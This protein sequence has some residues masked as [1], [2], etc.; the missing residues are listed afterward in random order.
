MQRV[1]E[2]QSNWDEREKLRQFA[3]SR[4]PVIPPWPIVAPAY[5]PDS[6]PRYPEPSKDNLRVVKNPANNS[7]PNGFSSF[8]QNKEKAKNKLD[9]SKM[10]KLIKYKNT[11]EQEIKETKKELQQNKNGGENTIQQS[12]LRKNI[13]PSAEIVNYECKANEIF[14]SLKNSKNVDLHSIKNMIVGKSLKEIDSLIKMIKLHPEIVSF[15]NLKNDKIQKIQ[16]D[17]GVQKNTGSSN[18][19]I[20]HSFIKNK[21]NTQNSKLGGHKENKLSQAQ[22]SKDKNLILNNHKISIPGKITNFINKNS[23][24]SIPLTPSVKNFKFKQLR[25]IGK[26]SNNTLNNK[27]HLYNHTSLKNKN[28]LHLHKQPILSNGPLNGPLNFPTFD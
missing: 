12:Y 6:E 28:S 3:I 14:Q 23:I 22:V 9:V 26:I 10:S 5:T 20:N 16:N 7:G 15:K 4:P 17:K 18:V 27:S 1:F 19:K 2:I 11:L 13:S 25:K 21:K 24:N 8:L